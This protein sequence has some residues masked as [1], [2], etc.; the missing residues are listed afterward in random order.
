MFRVNVSIYYHTWILWVLQYQWW[1]LPSRVLHY[2]FQYFSCDYKCSAIVY[3]F[4]LNTICH[5]VRYPCI[6]W[7]LAVTKPFRNTGGYNLDVPKHGHFILKLHPGIQK[8]WS[9]RHITDIFPRKLQHTPRAHP[10]QSPVRQLWKESLYSLLVKV[11]GCWCNNLR[12]L[13]CETAPTFC[14]QLNFL[15]KKKMANKNGWFEPSVTPPT[16]K[17]KGQ[18]MAFRFRPSSCNHEEVGNQPP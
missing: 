18:R 3:L 10:R 4:N 2:H 9:W 16:C 7:T 17:G 5:Y 8:N 6:R 13:G 11:W 14:V 1:L 15:Q 12:I